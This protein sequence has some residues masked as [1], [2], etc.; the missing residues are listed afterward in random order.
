MYQ[1]GKLGFVPSVSIRR[2]LLPEDA[3]SIMN[4]SPMVAIYLNIL[5]VVVNVEPMDSFSLDMSP[6]PSEVH[7]V[8]KLYRLKDI[9]PQVEEASEEIIDDSDVGET[10]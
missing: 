7:G 4:A 1:V 6:D 8:D 2:D 5:G 10:Y 3:K 9:E